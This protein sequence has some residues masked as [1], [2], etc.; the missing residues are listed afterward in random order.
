M[1]AG[2]CVSQPL[3]INSHSY[4]PLWNQM[5]DKYSQKPDFK[6]CPL[7][8]KIIFN[9]EQ[10]KIYSNLNELMQKCL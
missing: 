5:V 9:T 8:G 7:S 1:L 6:V 2:S 4:K 10:G 3:P